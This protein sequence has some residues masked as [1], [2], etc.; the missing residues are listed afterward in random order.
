M[1]CRCDHRRDGDEKFYANQ[2]SLRTVYLQVR[3]SKRAVTTRVETEYR[4]LD[5]AVRRLGVSRLDAEHVPLALCE[6]RKRHQGDVS[7]RSSRELSRRSKNTS[8]T[9]SACRRC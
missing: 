8:P 2:Y 3:H 7:S 5:R 4:A 6:I 9:S 1:S